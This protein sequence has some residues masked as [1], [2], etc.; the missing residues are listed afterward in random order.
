MRLLVLDVVL[1]SSEVL[2]IRN[3]DSEDV[4]YIV[5]LHNTVEFGGMGSG[6][7]KDAR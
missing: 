2:G 6:C 5:V 4:I 3:F 1:E 7:A